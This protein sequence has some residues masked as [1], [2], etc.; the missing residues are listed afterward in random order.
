MASENTGSDVLDQYRNISHKL[1]KY[2]LEA[3]ILKA[4]EAFVC[5][6][7]LRKPN[8]TE[9]CESFTNLGQ[10]CENEEMPSYAGLCWIAKARCEG[11]LGNI[12]GEISSLVRSA[13]QFLSSEMQDKDIGCITPFDENLHVSCV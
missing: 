8:V 2:E 9:A 1:K 12:T 6:R 3:A 5:R 4:T 10:H 7:F 11:S 13:R